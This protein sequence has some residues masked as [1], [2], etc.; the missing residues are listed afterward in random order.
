MTSVYVIDVIVVYYREV[1][2][3]IGGMITFRGRV[4][5]SRRDGDF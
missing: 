3:R 5:T 4:M 2:Y 1:N